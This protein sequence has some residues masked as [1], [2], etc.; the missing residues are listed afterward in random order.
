M[1]G[2]RCEEL[3][4]KPLEKQPRA[5]EARLKHDSGEEWWVP[6]EGRASQGK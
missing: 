3:S 5:E 4:S 6:G 1:Q 2:L